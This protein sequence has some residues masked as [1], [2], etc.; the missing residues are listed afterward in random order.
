MAR[1]RGPHPF[2]RSGEVDF[3]RFACVSCEKYRA[4]GPRERVSSQANGFSQFISPNFGLG[5]RAC[6]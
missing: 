3:W 6:G 4:E 5:T 1:S 2:G